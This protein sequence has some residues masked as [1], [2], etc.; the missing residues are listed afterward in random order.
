M[1]TTTNV[2]G[3]SRLIPVSQVKTGFNYRRRYNADAMAELREDIKL[4]G[5]LQPV[6][7]RKLDD[8]YQLIAGGRRFLAFSDVFGEQAEIK[9]E[10]R[11]MTDAEATAVMLAENNKREDPTAI[12]DAEGAARMLGLCNGDRDEAARRLGWNRNKLDRRAALMN[13]IQATCRKL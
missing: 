7:V 8:G 9:A 5:L 2:N 4:Q 3:E 13:A 12:E 11:V 6:I 1:E 10:V